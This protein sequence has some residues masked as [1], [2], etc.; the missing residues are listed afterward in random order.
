M[1]KIN[2]DPND[3]LIHYIIYTLSGPR[4]YETVERQIPTRDL[5]RIIFPYD[6]ISF[7]LYDRIYRHDDENN[8]IY[9]GE[10]VNRSQYYI[11]KVYSKEEFAKAVGEKSAVYRD[12]MYNSPERVIKVAGNEFLGVKS[13]DHVVLP[14]RLTFSSRFSIVPD[15]KE[16][17]PTQEK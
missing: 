9:M 17:A 1:P 16:P 12:V 15:V 13:T 8:T 2:I 4:N 5:K 11:G 10:I 14:N 3:E 6:C 7:E